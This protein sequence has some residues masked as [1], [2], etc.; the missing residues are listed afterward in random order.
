MARIRW[1]LR[2]LRDMGITPA[3]VFLMTAFMVLTWFALVGACCI[4]GM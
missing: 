2:R 4:G 3:R 1:E